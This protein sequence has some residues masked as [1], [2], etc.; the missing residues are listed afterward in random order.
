MM[1]VS[2]IGATKRGYGIKREL[3]NF[4]SPLVPRA[5]RELCRDVLRKDAH[6]MLP[7]CG[8]GRVLDTLKVQFAP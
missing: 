5:A 6:R 1:A 7:A 8:N 4:L 3:A 2:I